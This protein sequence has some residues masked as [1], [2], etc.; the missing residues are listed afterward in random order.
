[1]GKDIR[2]EADFRNETPGWK[3]NEWEMKGVP[4]RI[5][6]GPRDIEAGQAILTRRDTHQKI[7]VS[8]DTMCGAAVELL[9]DIQNNMLEKARANVSG[10]IKSADS[11]EGILNAVENKNFVRAKWCGL[12]ACEDEIKA[13]TAASS[14]IIEDNDT[15]G[16]CAVCGKKAKH[17][18]LYARAY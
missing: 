12:R 13:K 4:L 1:M 15:A 16:K 7:T 6:I 10:R 9:K 3:F 5:E 11:V 17:T 18:V 8:L 14:R 2:A